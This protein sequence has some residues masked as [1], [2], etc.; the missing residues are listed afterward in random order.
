MELLF[1]SCYEC[2]LETGN[3]FVHLSSDDNSRVSHIY[4]HF[5]ETDHIFTSSYNLMCCANES[6]PELVYGMEGVA[7]YHFEGSMARE[8]NNGNSL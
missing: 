1:W 8:G 5:V 6:L 7:E 4:K 3:A 2:W